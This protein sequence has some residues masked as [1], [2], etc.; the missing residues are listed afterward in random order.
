MCLSHR[1]RQGGAG[2]GTGEKGDKNKQGKA[3]EKIHRPYPCPIG[4]EKSVFVF[5]ALHSTIL[6]GCY[7]H[8]IEDDKAMQMGLG[9]VWIVAIFRVL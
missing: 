1:S 9:W 4:F 5:S 6:P 3:N 8:F 7:H 2:A